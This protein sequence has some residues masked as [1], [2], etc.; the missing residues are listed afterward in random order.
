[1]WIDGWS[2]YIFTLFSTKT[3]TSRCYHPG[4]LFLHLW[5]Q[6]HFWWPRLLQCWR[7]LLRKSHVLGTDPAA[8]PPLQHNPF[9]R[10]SSPL[11][12]RAEKLAK[13][14]KG[15]LLREAEAQMLLFF[16]EIGQKKCQG[17]KKAKPFWEPAYKKHPTSWSF[18]WP[19]FSARLNIFVKTCH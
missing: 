8:A 12:E 10:A 9:H 6:L 2:V 19:K 7:R 15:S 4:L 3:E 1:M 5:K 16:Q 17:K 18:T 14:P 13:P 11:S